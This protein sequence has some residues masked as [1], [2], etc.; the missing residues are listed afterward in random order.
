MASAGGAFA[1]DGG[2]LVFQ[3]PESDQGGTDLNGDGDAGDVVALEGGGLAIH[4]PE[5][6]QGGD[7][8]GDG[9][10]ID[11]VVHIWDRAT[12]VSTNLGLA[13]GLVYPVALGEGHFEFL[14]SE[15]SQGADLN[16]DGDTIDNV[17][18]VWPGVTAGGN[19]L[20]PPAVS[21]PAEAP[22]PTPGPR[23]G[24]DSGLDSPSGESEREGSGYWMGGQRRI[25]VCLPQ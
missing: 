2:R 21:P 8:N 4:V 22:V 14:V 18:H 16:G 5:F 9:D 12:G 19:P 13:G 11:E 7:L 15:Y 24:G 25:G 3:V 23:P 1:I 6:D 17:L 20:V 10:M